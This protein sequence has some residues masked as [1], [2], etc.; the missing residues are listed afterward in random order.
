MMM[1]YQAEIKKRWNGRA[2]IKDF[3]VFPRVK[4]PSTAVLA[5]R[6]TQA[7]WI[8]PQAR[9]NQ[10]Q[11]LAMVNVQNQNQNNQLNIKTPVQAPTKLNVNSQSQEQILANVLQKQFGTPNTGQA[12]AMGHSSCQ[13]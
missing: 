12:Q 1:M 7:E 6:V 5:P 9:I 8:G 10:S 2:Q 13:K 4:S 11:T 3:Y